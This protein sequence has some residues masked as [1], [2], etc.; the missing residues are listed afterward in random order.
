MDGIKCIDCEELRKRV[1]HIEYEE[2]K[3]VRGDIQGIKEDMARNNI[4]IA[5]SIDSSEK[6]NNTL[7]NVQ[8]TMIQLTENIKHNNNAMSNLESKVDKIANNG[9]IDMGEWFQKNWFNIVTLLGII[10]YIVFGQFVKI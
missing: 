4:L 8:T 10:A 1:N 7:S 2:L 3:E 5:Q 9:K 6:L